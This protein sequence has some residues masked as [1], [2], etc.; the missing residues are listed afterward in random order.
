MAAA[1][2]V[3]NCNSIALILGEKAETTVPGVMENATKVGGRKPAGGGKVTKAELLKKEILKRYKSVR[4]FALELGIPY[5]TLV[6]GM[7]RGI[8]SMSYETV[9]KTCDKLSLNPIDF[10]P[11]DQD[12]SLNAL[13]LKDKV[14]ANYLKLNDEGREKILGLMEDFAQLDKYRAVKKKVEKKQ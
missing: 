12:A 4:A 9:M 14:T 7:E 8:E 13:L 6:T 11:L 1:G 10:S 2:Y 3:V 5:S